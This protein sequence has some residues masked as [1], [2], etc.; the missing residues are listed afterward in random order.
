MG[1]RLKADAVNINQ[2]NSAEGFL[3]ICHAGRDRAQPLQAAVNDK[4]G[5]FWQAPSRDFLFQGSSG[6]QG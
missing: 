5:W 2:L 4:L 3:C 1:C 6:M